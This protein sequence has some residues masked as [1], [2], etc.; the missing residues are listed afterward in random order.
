MFLIYGAVKCLV[1]GITKLY[2]SRQLGALPIICLQEM[3]IANCYCD[4]QL[5]KILSIMC[6]SSRVGSFLFLIFLCN[7]NGFF[8]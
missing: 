4:F 2:N 8:S 1:S 7:Y 3:L 6:L 5:S